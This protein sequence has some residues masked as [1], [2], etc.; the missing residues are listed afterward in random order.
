MISEITVAGQE[1]GVVSV[2]AAPAYRTVEF[3]FKNAVAMNRSPFTG[4][5]QTY[6]WPGADEWCPM[7]KPGTMTLPLLMQPQVAA[8]KAFLMECC[9]PANPF[10]LGDPMQPNPAGNLQGSV[11]LVDNSPAGSNQIGMKVLTVKGL[12]A[13]RPRILLPW[14]YIGVGYRMHVVVNPV[15][16]DSTGKAAVAIWPSLREPPTDGAAL[17][18]N[19]VQGLFR[20][21]GNTETWSRTA[22]SLTSLSFQIMEYR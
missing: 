21:A 15:T 10:L 13:S 12:S 9:G 8:W 19:K 16:A 11:P 14:D 5:T 7:E 6:V 18:F 2:P 1:I 3:T 22:G 4:Q 17:K 20:L